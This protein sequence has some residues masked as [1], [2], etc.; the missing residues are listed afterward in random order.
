MFEFQPTLQGKL[1][2]I[3]PVAKNDWEQMYQAASDPAV[4]ALHPANDRYKEEVFRSYFD[5]ALESGSAF[6][7]I[8]KASGKICGSSRYH[9]LDL[10]LSEIEIGWTFLGTDYWGGTYNA[11]VKAL[12][13][14]HAFQYVDTV[15]FWIGETN[16][17]SRKAIEKIGASLREGIQTREIGGDS[18][19]VVYEIKK[20]NWESR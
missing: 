17:R 1:V 10:N 5:G 15:I 12:M 20:E 2:T 14:N 11:E 6:S 4:W 3:R 16:A 9:G 18:P 7:I 19:H 8:D 13:L